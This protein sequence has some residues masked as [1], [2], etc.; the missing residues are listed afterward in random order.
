MD[1]VK[2]KD[3]KEVARFNPGVGVDIGT[4]NAS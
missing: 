3:E 4:S 1:D 2:E